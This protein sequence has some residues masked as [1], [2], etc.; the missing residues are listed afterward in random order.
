MKYL[1]TL[2][3]ILPLLIFTNCSEE[4]KIMINIIPNPDEITPR[5]GYIQLT[6]QIVFPK[7]KHPKN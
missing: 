3:L 2:L 7:T 1:K 6:D 5:Q 4:E